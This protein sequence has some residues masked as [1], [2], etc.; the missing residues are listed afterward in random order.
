MLSG[1]VY[2]MFVRD[3]ARQHVRRTNPGYNDSSGFKSR[4]IISSFKE[5]FTYHNIY[6]LKNAPPKQNTMN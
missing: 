2:N 1:W 4:P 6:G 5:H 3:F